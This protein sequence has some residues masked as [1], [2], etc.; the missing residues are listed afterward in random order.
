LCCN[1]DTPRYRKKE[2]KFE[3]KLLA[4]TDE[5]FIYVRD[6]MQNSI[7]NHTGMFGGGNF[8]KYIISKVGILFSI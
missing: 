4:A 3:L 7:K 2:D 6:K 1:T 5:D 8:T